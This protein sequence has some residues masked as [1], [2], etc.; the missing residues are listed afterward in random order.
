MINNSATAQGFPP[1]GPIVTD[2][3]SVTVTATRTPS[4]NVVKSANLQ[5]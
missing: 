4:I 3:D 2:A 5:P 1:S